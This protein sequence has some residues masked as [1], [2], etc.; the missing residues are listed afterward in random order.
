M[1]KQYTVVT[2]SKNRSRPVT[3]VQFQTKVG[4]SVDRSTGLGRPVDRSRSTEMNFPNRTI[5]S[6]RILVPTFYKAFSPLYLIRQ[7]ISEQYMVELTSPP[8]RYTLTSYL[9]DLVNTLIL[10]W[11][12]PDNNTNP[13]WFSPILTW[14]VLLPP[15][16]YEHY[17]LTLFPLCNTTLT[18]LW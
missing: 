17:D 1:I 13:S 8:G 10:L 5:N 15:F 9:A 18:W 4:A 14:K 2:L 7:L 6:V 11:Y 3:I 12:T 16:I